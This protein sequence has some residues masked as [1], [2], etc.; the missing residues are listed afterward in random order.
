MSGRR[1]VFLDRD[2][3]LVRDVHLLTLPEQL[4]LLPGV[5]RALQLL[6]DAGLALVVVSNQ[7]V[8]ARGLVTE[9][10]VERVHRAMQQEISA[11]GGT[12]LDAV[13]YCPHH[14][15]ADVAAYR[16]DC[17]CRK[18]AT[19]MLLEA[20]SAH[21]LDLAASWMVGDRPS[22]IIA[23]RSAGCRT[24][25]V[26]SGKHGAAPIISSRWQDV[27]TEPDFLCAD[28]ARAALVVLESST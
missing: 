9:A 10:Q 19:G 7:T 20:A 5:P 22:D 24:V 25:Q 1:A 28:L 13:F 2:G 17:D 11:A 3:V 18:P 14:P 15:H 16:Q 8:V 6:H 21:Q 23:G 12:L 27:S 4:E 26:M